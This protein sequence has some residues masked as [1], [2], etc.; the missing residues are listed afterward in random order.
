[1]WP[2]LAYASKHYNLEEIN[3]IGYDVLIFKFIMKSK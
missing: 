1:M 3:L 2:V